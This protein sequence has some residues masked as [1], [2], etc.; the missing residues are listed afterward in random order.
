MA[1]GWLD[2]EDVHDAAVVRAALVQ[3]INPTL[4]E[5]PGLP[6]IRQALKA[7]SFGLF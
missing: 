3:C 2:A 7:I 1:R 6:P 4:S 5:R